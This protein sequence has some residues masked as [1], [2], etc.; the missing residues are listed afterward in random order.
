MHLLFTYLIPV[1]PLVVSLDGMVSSV[2]T[3]TGEEVKAMVDRVLNEKGELGQW[4]VIWG[5]EWHTWPIGEM[6]WVVGLKR[7]DSRA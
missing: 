3:R 2:R 4:D 5:S 6:S 1:V 7:S